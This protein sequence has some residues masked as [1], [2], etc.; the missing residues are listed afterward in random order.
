MPLKL[1][2]VR[3]VTNEDSA[4]VNLNTTVLFPP[5]APLPF[6]WY[7]TPEG[8]SLGASGKRSHLGAWPFGIA[9][10]CSFSSF[11]MSFFKHHNGNK[12][13]AKH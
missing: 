9:L 4:C 3:F 11:W 7:L 2:Y 12:G 8:G 6:P 1:F 5:R 13:R 10:A